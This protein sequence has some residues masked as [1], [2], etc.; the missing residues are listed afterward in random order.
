M[1]LQLTHQVEDVPCPSLSGFVILI[2][3]YLMTSKTV[4]DCA[5]VLKSRLGIALAVTTGIDKARYNMQ[6]AKFNIYN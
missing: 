6:H 4:K 2:K 3:A 1:S 5:C